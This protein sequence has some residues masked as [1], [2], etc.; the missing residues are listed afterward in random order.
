MFCFKNGLAKKYHLRSWL[1]N[2]FPR[3]NFS[4]LELK[5]YRLCWVLQYVSNKEP[6]RIFWM[7]NF[8]YR[9]CTEKK[10]VLTL[11]SPHFPSAG[12]WL[13]LQWCPTRRPWL[14]HRWSR[15][16]VP[17]TYRFSHGSRQSIEEHHKEQI[18]VRA[19]A[20]WKGL[21]EFTHENARLEALHVYWEVKQ[22]KVGLPI[23][24]AKLPQ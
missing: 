1:T 6:K 12:A 16:V 14:Y 4:N 10:A 17:R 21:F 15:L 19:D 7:N 8:K 11:L 22:L 5:I 24:L 13:L 20:T 9:I 23:A 18:V 2:S 3:I